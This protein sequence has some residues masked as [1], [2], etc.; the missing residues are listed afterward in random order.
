MCQIADRLEKRFGLH[1]VKPTHVRSLYGKDPERVRTYYQAWL[2]GRKIFIKHFGNA[3]RKNAVENEFKFG[4]RLHKINANNFPEVLFF[5]EVRDYRCIATEFIEGETLGA[6]IRG[7]NFPD[8]EKENVIFQ[9]KEIAKN[10]MESG[11]VHNDVG[12]RNLFVTSD[13]KLKLIDFGK[14]I[15]SKRRG[16]KYAVGK[17]PVLLFLALADRLVGLSYVRDM[18]RIL[19]IL[20]KIG[21]QES[22]QEVYRDVESFLKEQ[23]RT[24][25]TEYQYRLL[26]RTSIFQVIIKFEK[27]IKRN[28]H[29]FL[30][31]MKRIIRYLWR[32][33]RLLW[34]RLGW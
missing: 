4:E 27:H 29:S 34:Q 9:L 15:D 23:L 24:S 28:I 1:H 26:S 19:K 21:C 17:T 20:E 11:I 18:L 5:S 2:D 3:Y 31:F 32:C 30:Y 10:L 8:S 22:Y 16:K 13:G 7:N 25:G 33:F 12:P 14:T 6:K